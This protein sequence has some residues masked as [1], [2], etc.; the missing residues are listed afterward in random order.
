[1]IN[2]LGIAYLT[3]L[4]SYAPVDVGVNPKITPKLLI[5]KPSKVPEAYW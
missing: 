4:D 3:K 2:V 5:V 1:M